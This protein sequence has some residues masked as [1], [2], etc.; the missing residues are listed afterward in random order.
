MISYFILYIV[1][2]YVLVT[3]SM[4]KMNW[5][6]LAGDLQRLFYTWSPSLVRIGFM[7]SDLGFSKKVSQKS[8]SWEVTGASSGNSGVYRTYSI[9]AAHT[10][11]K[12]VQDLWLTLLC[13]PAK[14]YEDRIDKVHV[15]HFP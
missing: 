10:L 11:Y 7:G 8:V 4:N 9:Q 15:I 3:D 13:L 12:F 5:V 1:L 14:F 2:W 6:E